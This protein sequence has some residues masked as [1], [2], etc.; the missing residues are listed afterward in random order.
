MRI[1][2]ILSTYN[3]HERLSLVLDGY[4]V[5]SHADFEIVIADDGS[6]PATREVIGRARDETGLDVQH[7]WHEDDGFRKC[8][9]MNRAAA[10]T[11][12]DYLI[13]S[14]G[15]CIP[16]RDFIDTHEA[17]AE[18]GRF[19]SGG[20][21]RL[22][23]DATRSLTREDVLNGNV[24]NVRFLNGT[25]PRTNLRKYRLHLGSGLGRVL[26]TVTT[27]RATWNG[28]NSSCWRKDLVKAN[29]FD[30]RMCYGGEDR[31]FGERLMHAGIRPR[32]IRHRAI[33]VHLWH[34]RDYVHAEGLRYN[35]EIRKSTAVR[36]S[37]FTD[38]GIVK[39]DPPTP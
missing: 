24:T 36:R 34:D 32:Q 29:G 11:D 18:P 15:D 13:F 16:R 5:Q 33:C 22:T 28:H 9:I 35:R 30:E 38:H 25:L 3:S 31:E 4:R 12:A 23:A 26:D 37:R 2:V 6:G 17:L 1:A 7:V 10:E 27:T 8:T 21:F 14:D 19:L 39:T 20:C